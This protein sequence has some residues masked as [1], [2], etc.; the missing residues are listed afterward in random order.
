M[1]DAMRETLV[2]SHGSRAEVGAEPT[3]ILWLGDDALLTLGDG[4]VRHMT[5]AGEVAAH[6]VHGGAILAACRH[7]DGRSIVT[8][9]DDGR[10]CRVTA[11]GDFLELGR[12]DRRWVE[13]LV[14]S[15][16]SGLIV[17]GVGR[18]AVVWT[19][20]ATKPSHRYAIGSTIGGLAL[21]GK[22]KR[23][24]VS[25]YGGVSLFYAATA[26]SGRVALDWIGSH[27]ACTMSADGRYVVTAL[28]ETGLHG[29][30]LPDLRDMRM[31]GY[32]AKTRSFSWDRRG[33][34]L[35]TSGDACAVLWSF[36]GKSGPMDKPP[37]LLAERRGAIVTRVAFHPRSDLLAVG[38]DDGVVVLT[39]AGD[40]RPLLVDEE[41]AAITALSWNDAGTRLGWGDEDGRIGILDMAARA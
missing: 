5:D 20:G 13:H 4:S 41:G 27:L 3:A 17:A 29:W 2:Q 34:W 9:G 32:V 39:Q 26:G 40:D 10:V 8:G 24:A 21:D 23:L 12:F 28:Q 36:D 22:G 14:A 31:S 33:K 35:A 18:E 19:P 38:Y 25:H 15:P 37:V 1:I 16:A 7:P 30:R 11:Y 6:P